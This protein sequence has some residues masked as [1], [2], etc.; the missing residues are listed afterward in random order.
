[1]ALEED[2]SVKVDP[3]EKGLETT[4]SLRIGEWMADQQL[5]LV[6]LWLVMA[7]R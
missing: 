7:Y 6:G 3:V 2:S 5:I 1:M 4:I